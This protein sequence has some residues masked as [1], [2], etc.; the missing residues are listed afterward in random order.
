LLVNEKLIPKAINAITNQLLG[1]RDYLKFPHQ[2]R[3]HL[4]KIFYWVRMLPGELPVAF[5]EKELHEITDDL[6]L[7]QDNEI[8]LAR[9]RHLRK[10]YLPKT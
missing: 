5:H 1:S 7:W 9:L 4:K 10:E 3:Q 6:G 2:L 8:F